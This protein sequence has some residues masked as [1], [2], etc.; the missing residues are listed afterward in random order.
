MNRKC[1]FGYI[2]IVFILGFAC[3]GPFFAQGSVVEGL[4]VSSVSITAVTADAGVTPLPTVTPIPVGRARNFSMQGDIL[5]V[6]ES[7]GT[8]V[9][10]VISVT[11]KADKYLLKQNTV[12][13]AAN[14][15]ILKK[16]YRK[17]QVF[18][19]LMP[20]DRVTINGKLM[21]GGTY[22]A[23]KIQTIA[24]PVPKK[25]KKMAHK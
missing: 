2:T 6:R 22:L 12:I 9:I 21:P 14:S 15:Q 5:E 18:T 3:T 20:G 1:P 16:P 24:K 10:N 8:I 13:D 11:V 19:V 23:Q 25:P 17:N 7:D 4:S